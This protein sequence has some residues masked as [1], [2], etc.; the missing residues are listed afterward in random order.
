MMSSA[1]ETE[2]SARPTSA[3]SFFVMMVTE[4]FG[5]QGV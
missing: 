4:T 1:H 3:P 2:A 5:T